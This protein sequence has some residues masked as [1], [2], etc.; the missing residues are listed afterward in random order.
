VSD[1]KAHRSAAV[2]LRAVSKHYRIGKDQPIP[3]A[4]DVSQ[5]G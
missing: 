2:E 5:F 1:N 4:D 3:A